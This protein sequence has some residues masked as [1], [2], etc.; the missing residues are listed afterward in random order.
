VPHE[1]DRAFRRSYRNHP[2]SRPGRRGGSRD[3]RPT[4]C[5]APDLPDAATL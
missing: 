3:P 2:A 1:R 4:R 5:R